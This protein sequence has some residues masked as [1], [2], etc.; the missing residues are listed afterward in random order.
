MSMLH[1][2][3]LTRQFE[4]LFK[5][6]YSKLYYVALDWVENEES[7]KDLVN[8]LFAELWKQYERLQ[9]ENVEGYLFQSLRNRCINYLKHQRVEQEY[10]ERMLAEKQL[11]IDENPEIHEARLKVIEQTLEQM[12]PQTRRVFEQCFFEGKRYQEVANLME[13][14]VSTIHK[15]MTQ[16]FAAFRAAFGCDKKY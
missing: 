3:Q 7:A 5:K 11:V 13:V 8:D 12:N 1:A 6:N 14:S 2:P 15:R 9:D 10:R 4:E 16:A